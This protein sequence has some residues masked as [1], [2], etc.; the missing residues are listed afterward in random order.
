MQNLKREIDSHIDTLANEL[1]E[2]SRFIYEHPEVALQEK[3]AAGK[4]TEVLARHGFQ[5]QMPAVD[6]D[7]AFV[8]SLHHGKERPHVAFVAQYDALLNL[9]HA[10]GHNLCTTA[11]LGAALGTAKILSALG[12]KVSV[13]G[14]PSEEVLTSSGKLKMIEA[15]IFEDV[16]AAIATHPHTGTYLA[17]K[18][19][20]INQV[21][22]RFKGKSAHA[23]DIP[24]LGVNAYDAV[25]L[26]F[27][28]LSFLRQQLRQ[29]ARVHWGEVN[30]KGPMNV[31]PDHASAKIGLRASDNAYTEEITQKAVNCIKGAAMMT[32]CEPEYEIFP[33]YESL[34]INNSL[35]D[36][37]RTNLER[38]QVIED[39]LPEFGRA[40]STDMGNVSQVVPAIYPLF[41]ISD[42]DPPHSSEFCEA[43]GT[44]S[45][46][47]MTLKMSK[48]MAM[49][50]AR[51][52]KDAGFLKRIRKD[53]NELL[54]Y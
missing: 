53:F 42:G 19:L 14:T 18:F 49:T 52:L 16:D 28:G 21:S 10:C 31:I 7:T 12:G 20:A 46:F 2:V 23:G 24:Y 51:C 33:G 38:F 3:K 36:E 22:V 30:I 13:I 5:V 40:G 17:E 37:L 41:K 4:I 1:A 9:G 26:T 54:P 27:I 8:A 32:G 29:D 6:M 50:G 48:A 35:V 47:D 25:Q 45:A 39:P 11:S 44:E 15:G 43:A 34:K